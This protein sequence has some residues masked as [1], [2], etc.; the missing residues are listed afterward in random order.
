MLSYSIELNWH[1]VYLALCKRSYTFWRICRV[2]SAQGGMCNL[3]FFILIHYNA[4]WD[5]TVFPLLHINPRTLIIQVWL[6]LQCLT[7][8]Y[9]YLFAMA[10]DQLARLFYMPGW[11]KDSFQVLQQS[12]AV[13]WESTLP[14]SEIILKNNSFQDLIM[15]N[16]NL[17]APP[18]LCP[19]VQ[20]A[21]WENRAKLIYLRTPVVLR[22][23]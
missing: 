15:S 14:S 8:R 16:P 18:Q 19:S 13:S 12:Q 6:L 9:L 11:N 5:S 1:A 20:G 10:I 4:L 23:W 22:C 2:E 7:G 17:T 21:S 3:F